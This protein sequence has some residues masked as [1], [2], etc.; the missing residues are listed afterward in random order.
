VALLTVHFGK[1]GAQERLEG[2]K[3][4]GNDDTR[5]VELDRRISADS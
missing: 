1:H 3:I 4:P 5:E 2:V